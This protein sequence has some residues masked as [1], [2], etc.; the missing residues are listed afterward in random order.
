MDL[1]KQL[2]SK[3]SDSRTEQIIAKI[4]T[5][6][7]LI[8]SKGPD[9]S[10]PLHWIAWNGPTGVLEWLLHRGADITAKSNHGCTTLHWAAWHDSPSKDII[11]IL[12]RARAN[13]TIK[14]K[15]QHTPL[16]LADSK[17]DKE[18]TNLLRNAGSV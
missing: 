13:V 2:Q 8:F 4:T 11:Q 18:I 1:F 12:L 14:T 7:L 10:T 6:P 3:N 5:T 9:N 15:F 16:Q 17:G